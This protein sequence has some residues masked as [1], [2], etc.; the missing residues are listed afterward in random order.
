MIEA[1]GV[2]KRYGDLE[3]VRRVSFSI[4]ERQVIGL[5]GH[6]GAGKTTIMKMLTGYLEPNEG[7]ILIDGQD[8]WHDRIGVRKKLGYLPENCPVYPEMTVV[9]YLCFVAEMR[10]L[11]RDEIPMLVRESIN[12]T[13]LEEK[14]LAQI[15]T[16]SRG[17]QQR[18]GVAQ[19]ILHAPKIIILDE[20]TNGLDPSQIGDM[21]SLIRD[22]AKHSTIILST[23]ILQEVEAICDRVIIIRRGQVAVD[24]SLSQLQQ[25]TRLDISVNRELGA[26]MRDL[27]QLPSVREVEQ[28]PDASGSFSY[29]IETSA[30]DE[31]QM[32]SLSAAVGKRLF[33]QGFEVYS[34]HIAH[35]NLENVFRNASS[36]GGN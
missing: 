14:A 16:L 11:H 28:T 8:A 10:G 26:T 32:R 23:H 24:S 21:R 9:D 33:E 4:P 25:S 1:T 20:P 27:A 3:A 19:A 5:L 15:R 29:S 30:G 13:R 18:V 7:V 17:F 35:Q 6:N 2:S 22:L 34:L 31:S 12:R 36:L